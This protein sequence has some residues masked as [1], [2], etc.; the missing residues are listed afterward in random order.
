MN[1]ILKTLTGISIAFIGNT[2]PSTMRQNFSVFIDDGSSY[3]TSYPSQSAYMQWYTSPTL[4]EGTHTIT[5]TDMDGTD[6][7]YALVGVS[8]QT[9]A[10]GKDILVDSASDSIVWV[11]DWQTNTSILIPT[12]EDFHVVN[13][14]LGNSTKDSRTS[15]DNFSFQFTGRF[16]SRLRHLQLNI[17][18]RDEHIGIRDSEEFYK[19]IHL[20]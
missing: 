9:T 10:L 8:D 6:V 16:T 2:P 4:E 12:F 15:G 13:Y 3:L 18:N 17:F 1:R 14:P 5:I 7:D 20:C 11:G 19:R